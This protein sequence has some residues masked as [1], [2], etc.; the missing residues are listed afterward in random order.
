[1]KILCDYSDVEY[2]EEIVEEYKMYA[3]EHQSVVMQHYDM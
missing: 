3:N 2:L 1:M